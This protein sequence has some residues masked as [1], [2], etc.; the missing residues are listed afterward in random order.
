MKLQLRHTPL[1]KER[2]H[3]LQCT[4]AQLAVQRH[5]QLAA[6]R[7]TQLATEAYITNNAALGNHN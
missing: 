7:H 4:E 1:L 2:T 3:T 5:A 6:Q